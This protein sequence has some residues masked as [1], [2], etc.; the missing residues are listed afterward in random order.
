MS[1]M[2]N[3]HLNVPVPGVWEFARGLAYQLAREQLAA[4]DDIE[5]QCAKSGAQ[6][7][8]DKKTVGIAHLGRTYRISLPDGE[9]SFAGSAEAVP[10]R[11]KILLSHYF[12]RVRGTPLTGNLITYKELHDGMNYYPTFYKR[13]IE[14]VIARFKDEPQKLLEVG[15][16]MDG[17][18]A[19]Y[20]DSAVTIPAFPRVPV[21]FVLWRGD[22][23]FAPDGSIL[24][25]STIPDY[26]PIED[27]TILCEVIAWRL[28]RS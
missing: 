15:K 12:T 26:L 16:I 8:P 24:F 19:E 9:V 11:D 6:C 13:A 10:L 28:A 7:Q 3:K 17:E 2:V 18:K 25:D 23:E 21:T 27:I 14:P 5:G 1:G 22:K 4:I 20:G